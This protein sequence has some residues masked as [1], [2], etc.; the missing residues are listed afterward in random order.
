[1]MFIPTIVGDLATNEIL[2]RP[3]DDAGWRR[4]C[5][6]PVIVLVQGMPA[7]GR[8][9]PAEMAVGTAPK[10]PSPIGASGTRVADR[11]SPRRLAGR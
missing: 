5:P 8:A 9:D 6:R 10:R 3:A 4:R 1:M 2:P 7:S 11:R